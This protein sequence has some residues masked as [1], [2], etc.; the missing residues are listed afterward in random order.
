[1]ISLPDLRAALV[2]ASL[3]DAA[4]LRDE[5]I[6]AGVADWR[7][8]PADQW[9]RLVRRSFWRLPPHLRPETIEDGRQPG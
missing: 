7:A 2:E 9:A 4:A 6:L 5:L 1:M 8:L 3:L